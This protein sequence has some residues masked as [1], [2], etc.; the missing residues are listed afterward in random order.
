MKLPTFIKQK[1]KI[2][3]EFEQFLDKKSDV[4]VEVLAD[5]YV[6]I[7][8]DLS[9][10]KTFYP[11]SDIIPYLNSLANRAHRKIY[12]SKKESSNKLVNFFKKE[13][14]LMFYKYQKFYSVYLL[15]AVS[16]FSHYSDI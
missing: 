2:W 16:H 4:D 14:P 6:E 10:A 8:E 5:L 13:F 9:Y 15:F 7:L 1:N 12:R 11:K 3:S